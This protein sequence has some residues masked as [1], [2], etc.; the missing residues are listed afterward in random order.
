MS[1]S[2][3]DMINYLRENGWQE[4]T[5]EQLEEHGFYNYEIMKKNS[6]KDLFIRFRSLLNDPSVP[7]YYTIFYNEKTENWGQIRQKERGIARVSHPSEPSFETFKK[8]LLKIVDEE[9]KEERELKKII[10]FRTCATCVFPK[11]ID[12][13]R[14]CDECED[15]S[16]YHYIERCLPPEELEIITN[17][18]TKKPLVRVKVV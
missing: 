15:F 10:G 18:V 1:E 9:K 3:D 12:G 13:K 5:E 16:M 8:H 7:I 17:E 14:I 11:V 6:E 4:G 2:L